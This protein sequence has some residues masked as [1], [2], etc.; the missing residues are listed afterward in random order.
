[1]TKVHVCDGTCG[2]VIS[3][4]QFQGGL[5]RCGAEDCT[6]EG[7]PFTEKMKCDDCGAVY[8]VDENHSH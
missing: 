4:E 6:R 5:T 2:A 8:A 7:Q 1:M 3:E